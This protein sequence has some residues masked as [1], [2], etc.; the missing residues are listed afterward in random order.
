MY[1]VRRNCNLMFSG[2]FRGVSLGLTGF[3]AAIFPRA[4]RSRGAERGDRGLQPLA[5]RRWPKC[6][7]GLLPSNASH[8]VGATRMWADR[9]F[10]RS[11]DVE[12][13]GCRRAVAYLAVTP[14]AVSRINRAGSPPGDAFSIYSVSLSR[15]PVCDT[16]GQETRCRCVAARRGPLRH[17]QAR[18]RV[19]WHITR[20]WRQPRAPNFACYGVEDATPRACLSRW[21]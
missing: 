16:H 2:R 8:P 1:Q 4:G 3:S 13:L 12:A 15:W 14:A 10:R 11:R 7:Y 21:T 6:Q 18:R 9:Y 20:S 5:E 19:G 17:A